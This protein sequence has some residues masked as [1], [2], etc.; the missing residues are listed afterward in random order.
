MHR[1]REEDADLG[2]GSIGGGLVLVGALSG[3]SVE[4]HPP[5]VWSR[6]GFVADV[7]Q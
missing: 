1:Q 4:K 5:F 2:F 6:Y 7:Y 3:R